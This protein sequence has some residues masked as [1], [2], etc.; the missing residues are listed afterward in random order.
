[1][2]SQVPSP[3]RGPMRRQSGRS[4]QSLGSNANPQPSS[5]S[6][7]ADILSFLAL[8][9]VA[10]S[11]RAGSEILPLVRRGLPF[12]AFESL[13]RNAGVPQKD[14]ASAMG[15]PATT[16][17]RRRQAGR[18]SPLESDQVVRIARL[19][20]AARRMMAGDA[21]ATRRWLSTPHRLLGGEAPLHH[22]STEIGGR[23]VEQLIGQ[24]GHGVFS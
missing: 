14:I 18:L 19:V 9:P 21:K 16:L 7:N 23:E 2:A 10:A 12:A 3:Q 11:N 4:A 8:R 1:M 6:E 17:G 24:I 20:I 22:A 13:V 5:G 15:M